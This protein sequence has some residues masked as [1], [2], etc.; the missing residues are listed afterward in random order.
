MNGTYTFFKKVACIV[1]LIG[2]SASGFA[3]SVR[4]SDDDLYAVASFQ[5]MIIHD[6][7]VVSCARKHGFYYTT[8]GNRFIDRYGKFFAEQEAKALR[9]LQSLGYPF[10]DFADA[11][12]KYPR[13]LLSHEF[14]SNLGS[15]LLARVED[16][17]VVERGIETQR[18]ALMPAFQR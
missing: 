12:V 5:Y 13:Q 6:F 18:Q 2:C 1:V 15:A 17:K 14:C 11:T 10:E 16:V 7:Y 9:V 3:Q 4:V 8:L